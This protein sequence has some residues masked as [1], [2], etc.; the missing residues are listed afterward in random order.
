M[1]DKSL[2]ELITEKRKLKGTGL[3][4]SAKEIGISPTTLLKIE[5]GYH[6]D[7][8]TLIKICAWLKVKQVFVPIAK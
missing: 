2:S 5:Q 1:E 7:P 8:K 6:P 3:R 4:P